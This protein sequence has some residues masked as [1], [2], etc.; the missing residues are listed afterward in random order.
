MQVSSRG[1]MRNPGNPVET[2]RP[3]HDAYDHESREATLY[4]V[5]LDTPQTHFESFLAHG[6]ETRYDRPVAL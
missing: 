4:H 1:W 6:P 2:G 3:A 5:C